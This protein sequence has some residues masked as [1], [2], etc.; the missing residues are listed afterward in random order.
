MNILKFKFAMC[1]CLS[2]VA[3]QAFAG[4]LYLRG[5][6]NALIRSSDTTRVYCSIDPEHDSCKPEDS[7]LAVRIYQECRATL[8]TP[9]ECATRV[10]RKFPR[11]AS[12]ANFAS[13][14][15]D[16]CRSGL[17]SVEECIDLCF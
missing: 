9:K 17:D 11:G 10:K 5:G 15:Y 13:V 1:L 12:C 16:D 2:L 3:I 14:C 8:S 6:E 4:E 7:M